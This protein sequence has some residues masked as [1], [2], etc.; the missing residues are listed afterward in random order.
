[1]YTD[2]E[3]NFNES[4]SASQIPTPTLQKMST[5]V[6]KDAVLD[7]S[8][9]WQDMIKADVLKRTPDLSTA[10]IEAEVK[11]SWKQLKIQAH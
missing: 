5:I 1:M 10:E 11:S 7:D 4:Q 3:I 2:K 9:R 8:K 6:W